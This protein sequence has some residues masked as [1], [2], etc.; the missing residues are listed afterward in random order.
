[1]D[2]KPSYLTS[3]I[4]GA[5]AGLAV[6]ISL[7]PLDTIKTRL[8]SSAGFKSSGGFARLYRGLG[9]AVVGSAPIAGLFFCTYDAVSQRAE[10]LA[11]ERY[12]PLAHVG[13]AC[14]AEVASCLAKVPTEVVKQRSQACPGAA[15][16]SPLGV[17]RAALAA[18]G[19]RGLYRGLASTVLRE[20][21]FAALQFPLWELLKASWRRRRRR[22]LGVPEVA[23]CGAVAGGVSAG[24]TTPLDVA[25]TRIML[26][27]ARSPGDGLKVRAVLR[28]VYRELGVR[29]LF[30]GFVPRVTWITVGGA[31]FFGTYEATKT[32]CTG[33]SWGRR[34][35]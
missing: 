33:Y 5:A 24:V 31:V 35:A 28:A 8:Q 15:A 21:P 9:P 18:E 14:A 29:G 12:R 10:A 3:L 16:P 11:G 19:P 1:M 7:F 20:L 6:D 4:A 25:K 26:A 27:K 32:Y 13:A 22:D 34:E 30:A 2:P 23:A 17:L